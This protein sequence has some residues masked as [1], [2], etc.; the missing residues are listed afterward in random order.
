MSTLRRISLAVFLSF[1]PSCSGLL[2][3]HSKRP[4]SGTPNI[5]KLSD[6]KTIGGRGRLTDGMIDS[7][8]NYYGM[9]VRANAGDLEAMPRAIWASLM[10]RVSTDEKPQHQYC[11]P[12][13]ESWCGWQAQQAGGE[14]YEHHNILPKAIFEVIK[15]LYIR[16]T[17]K[18]LL[19]RCLRGATQNQNECFNGLVWQIS[20]KTS[21]CGA[22]VVEFAA[23]FATSWFNDG[24]V[25]VHRILEEMHLEPGSFTEGA[26]RVLDQSRA[27]HAARK[28]SEAEKRG[29]KRRRRVR[30]GLQDEELE[31][32]GVQY[33]AGQF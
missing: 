9:A 20:P 21:F 12:G 28:A 30:K 6:N 4:V 18:A 17:D 16:L 25:A 7:L 13:I 23:A 2:K 15:P 22:V 1:P 10:H 19:R 11:P 27:Y 14:V 31:A 26:L 5:T 32:E 24:A 33:E 8:Q 29:R 3:V